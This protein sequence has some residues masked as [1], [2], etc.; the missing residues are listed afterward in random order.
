MGTL[1]NTNSHA[2][3]HTRTHTHTDI[4]RHTDSQTLTKIR[5]EQNDP[6]R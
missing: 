2:I 5:L 3:T 1:V 6:L 4:Y